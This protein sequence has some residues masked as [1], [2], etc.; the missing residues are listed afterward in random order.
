MSNCPFCNLDPEPNAAPPEPGEGGRRTGLVRRAWRSV[1]WLF[2]AG[3]LLLMPKCPMCIAA[4]VALFTGIG[5]TAATAWW[6]R[7]L[8]LALCLTW[9][10]YLAVRHTIQFFQRSNHVHRP[11]HA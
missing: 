10:A 6:I 11:S 2:P 3:L 9:L 1:Q 4:Y 7:I 5:I 8:M